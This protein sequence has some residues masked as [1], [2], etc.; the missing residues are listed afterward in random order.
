MK[1]SPVTAALAV[2]ELARHGRFTEIQQ[3]FAPQMRPMV[4]AEVAA[5]ALA[6]AVRH[7]RPRG[8]PWG[9]K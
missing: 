9:T 3:Q 6:R 7:C 2:V 1:T 4:P 8:C 5:S